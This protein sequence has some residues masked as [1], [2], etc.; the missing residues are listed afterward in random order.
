MGIAEREAEADNAAFTNMAA[1]SVLRS[2]IGAATQLGRN[3]N[4]AW[5][6]IADKIVIP[7]RGQIIVSHDGYRTDEEKGGT[8]DPLMGVFPLGF[9]M[10]PEIE[11]ATLEFYLNLRK[12]Y[13][14]SPML[15]ALYGV[16]AARTGDR[17]LAAKL[18][19]E[20][21]GRFCIGRFSQTLEYREDVFPEQPRAAPF[22]ANLA[23]FLMSLLLGFPGL[24]PGLGDPASWPQ[25]KIVLPQG[26]KAIEI[27]Q[28][29][30]HR[31]PTRL[32]ARQGERAIL[33]GI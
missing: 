19:D 26:W 21:Y 32:V 9:E 27:D 7:M 33:T 22:F 30:I 10:S 20:G 17:M 1:V 29:W 6:Q 28:V 24:Q 5:A 16:W 25:R 12:G 31:K 18:L 14:G 3:A 15:S 23:G 4:P 8:P 11:A 2:A 13:I